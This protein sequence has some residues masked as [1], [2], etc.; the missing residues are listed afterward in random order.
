MFHT[1]CGRIAPDGALGP[2][3]V[4]SSGSAQIRAIPAPRRPPAP[5]RSQPMRVSR[6]R[7]QRTRP[8]MRQRKAMNVPASTSVET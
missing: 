3:I 6:E 2:A 4:S 1:P 5:R 7:P 8:S